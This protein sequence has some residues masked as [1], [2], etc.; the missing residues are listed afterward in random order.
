MSHLPSARFLLV[1]K[2]SATMACDICQAYCGATLVQ[3]LQNTSGQFACSTKIE[4]L[5]NSPR[6]Q[7]PLTMLHHQHRKPNRYTDAYACRHRQAATY[8]KTHE[9][10]SQQSFRWLHSRAV[11]CQ[12]RCC[13]AHTLVQTM[14]MALCSH[15]Q[16]TSNAGKKPITHASQRAKCVKDGAKDSRAYLH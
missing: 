2:D 11:N 8:K 5:Q 14:E 13:G 3:H 6:P 16:Y 1:S 9:Y 12:A 4:R 15:W 10:R 7:Q